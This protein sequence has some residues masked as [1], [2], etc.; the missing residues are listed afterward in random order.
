MICPGIVWTSNPA[1]GQGRIF[2]H[3]HSNPDLVIIE[4]AFTY[5]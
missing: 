5:A 1:K 4:K 2:A 3:G